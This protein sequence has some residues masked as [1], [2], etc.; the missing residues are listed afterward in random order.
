MSRCAS[1]K[2]TTSGNSSSGSR[3]R[4]WRTGKQ[5]MMNGGRRLTSGKVREGGLSEKERVEE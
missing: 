1:G 3:K 2:G 4:G 5:G